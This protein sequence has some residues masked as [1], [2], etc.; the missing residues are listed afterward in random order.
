[1]VVLYALAL[2]PVSLLPTLLG[3]PG[4]C[5]ST[6]RSG[7]VSC[8]PRRARCCHR[9][10]AARA[11]R[12]FLRFDRV[13]PAL[14]TLMVLDT[15]GGLAVMIPFHT[16]ASSAPAS[17]FCAGFAAWSLCGAP[18]ARHRLRAAG[19]RLGVLSDQLEALPRSMTP[20]LLVLMHGGGDRMDLIYFW[21]AILIV[22]LPIAI[23]VTIGYLLLAGVPQG[24]QA[25][26]S[27]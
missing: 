22:L 8:T 10:D 20:A 14:L 5:T 16:A 25:E 11:W 9:G 23:F 12:V 26:R 27:H 6:A 17:L 4:R 15:V 3:S 21:S 24:A 19:R 2:L 18:A 1:M 13:L 7:S